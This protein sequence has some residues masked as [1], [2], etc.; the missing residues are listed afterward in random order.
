MIILS[1]FKAA[2][3]TPG[4]FREPRGFLTTIHAEPVKGVHVK[5]LLG[6]AGLV[7]RRGNVAVALPLDGIIAA[8][9]EHC[10][11]LTLTSVST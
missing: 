9:A 10:P 1:D 7:V 5:I 8:A 4:E 6:S 2:A 3:A 11:E